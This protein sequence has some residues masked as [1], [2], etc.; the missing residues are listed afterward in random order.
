M[1]KRWGNFNEKG[2]INI[3]PLVL[4]FSDLYDK[5]KEVGASIFT[6]NIAFSLHN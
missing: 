4:R 3:C 6:T 1:G 2:N 5:L